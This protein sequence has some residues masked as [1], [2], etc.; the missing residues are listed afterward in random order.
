MTNMTNNKP[1]IIVD[2]D[3]QTNAIRL[4][5]RRIF[6]ID[7]RLG[8]MQIESLNGTLWLTLPDDPNDYVLHSGE[9]LTVRSKGK[10]RALLQ[11]L[12]DASFTIN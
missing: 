7:Q 1:R 10:G 2:D 3:E 5:A 9:R 11:A 8:D 12:S 4:P 6:R